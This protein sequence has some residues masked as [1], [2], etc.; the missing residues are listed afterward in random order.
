VLPARMRRA[1]PTSRLTTTNRGWASGSPI[2]AFSVSVFVCASLAIFQHAVARSSPAA[3]ETF[4]DVTAQA[5]ITWRHFSGASEDRF[6]IETMG[7][8][9]A[10]LDF[11]GD[12]LQDI[13][14]VNGGETPHGKSA[15]PVHNALYQNLGDGRFQE[16]AAK[17]G[18]D[19]L[20]FYGMGV[21][22]ADYDNDGH[23]DLYVTGF[24]SSAL[25]HNNGDGT[26]RDVTE[27]AGVKNAGR[28]AASAAWFD[29]DCDGY[30]DLLV[31]NYVEFSFDHPKKCE[32][33]GMRSYCEQK[34]YNGMPLT[35]YHNNGD[36][37][38]SDVSER[39]GLAKLTGRALGVVA[40][41]VNDDGWPDVF[42]ARDA[43]TNLLLINGKNGTF[44]D[45]GSEYEVAYD[46]NG[47]AKAGMGVDAGDVNGD[48]R[49]DFVVTNFNDEYTSLFL[50]S[51]S[52]LY[53]DK[54]IAW[55]LSSATKSYVSWGVHLLDYDNDGNLDLAMVNGHINLAVESTRKDVKFK[56][57][58]LLLHN[59]GKGAFQKVSDAAGEPFH[60]GYTAR[61]LAVGDFNNDGAT[62]LVFTRLD[63]T[64]VL[65]RN[66]A[67]RENAWIGFELQGTKSNRDAIG[68]KITVTAG[69]RE[70][71]RWI[72]GGS[73]Y[74]SSHDKRVVVGLGGQPSSGSIGAEIRWPS[75]A[76]QRLSDL[77]R[78][79]YNK[80][81]EAGES[82]ESA[83]SQ[84]N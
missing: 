83:V 8:G 56:E 9:V 67:G 11:D 36:G 3:R 52:G 76:V 58:P 23:S 51:P 4:T 39:S 73:S 27:Q 43:S 30:L 54:T 14:F 72:T 32:M 33:N 16:I 15:S 29:Y 69:N 55:R 49:P 25:F 6:L 13:F 70:L 44:R 38:F 48:G 20:G 26:F 1:L 42:V 65:L 18:L 62:D 21:A 68:A 46:S 7:G 12:G 2:L 45:A 61:G 64:P 75:G 53:D 81:T 22:A 34:A 35:L 79:H 19:K 60:N 77:K 31:T 17:A 28:W 78:N 71:V 57:P 40:V 24:P 59:D 10:F 74:L 82:N 47:H 80:I 50:A 5:G 84:P 63:D 41:D 37:T 66:N